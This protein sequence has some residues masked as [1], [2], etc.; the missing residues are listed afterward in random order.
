MDMEHN[1]IVVFEEG[2][3]KGIDETKRE[4]A[5]KLLSSGVSLDIITQSTGLS[6][7]EIQALTKVHA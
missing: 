1:R 5:S 2:E 7:D 6:R 3:R 4:I